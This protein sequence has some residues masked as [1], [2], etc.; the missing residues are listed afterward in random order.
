MVE[1]FRR[2]S[3]G[4]KPVAY[5]MNQVYLIA[6]VSKQGHQQ[7]MRRQELVRNKESAYIGLIEKIREL[8]PGMGLRT[9]YTQFEPCG[10]GR[11]GFIA[12]GLREG[13]RLRAFESPVK[14]T[15]SVKSAK[16][17]NLLVDKELK[18]INQV[19]V[20]DITY[21]RLADRHYYLVLIM[22][23]YSRRILGYNV[24]DNMRAENNIAALEM[25]LSVRGISDYEQKLIHHSDRGSQ[26]ISNNYTD[27]LDQ[28]G[29]QI[30]MCSNVLENA[31]CERLNGTIKND[32]LS[33]WGI[34]NEKQLYVSTQKAVQNYNNRLHQSLQMTPLEFE[35]HI[36]KLNFKDRPKMSIFTIQ[37]QIVN[38]NPNQLSMFAG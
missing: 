22:D 2:C 29:I 25:A 17:K 16:F 21:Y 13:Y 8:H 36:N 9:M 33:R 15:K 18:G 31:H 11:D 35:A 23:V 14:T 5:K 24:A 32:Y 7:S 37:K 26:Y 4:E 34:R 27:L 38:Q 10:I 3:K 30:S 6:R 1:W 20:S 19:W 28:F 12:L